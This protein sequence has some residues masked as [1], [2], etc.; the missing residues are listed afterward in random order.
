MQKTDADYKLN[1]I[2][3]CK[4]S[5]AR[6]KLPQNELTIQV[7]ITPYCYSNKAL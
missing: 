3:N 5:G 1:Q 2:L 4:E 7:I 6:Y